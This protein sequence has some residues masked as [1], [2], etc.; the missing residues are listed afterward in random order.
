LENPHPDTVLIVD[1][2]PVEVD[3]IPGDETAD[4]FDIDFTADDA[5]VARRLT[6]EDPWQALIKESAERPG[7]VIEVMV[8]NPVDCDGRPAVP[9][10]TWT[11]KA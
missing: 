7:E 11:S 5:C 2:P 3:F 9:P 10:M 4:D 1:R 6:D 8:F